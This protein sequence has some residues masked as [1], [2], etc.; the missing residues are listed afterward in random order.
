LVV[1]L[2][3]DLEQR[4]FKPLLHTRRRR[5]ICSIHP[6]PITAVRWSTPL[7]PTLCHRPLKNHVCPEPL[8]FMWSFAA[9]HHDLC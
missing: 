3:Y 2:L 1:V 9:I 8:Q 5:C 6:I 4:L 7:K